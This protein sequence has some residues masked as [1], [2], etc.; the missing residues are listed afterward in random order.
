MFIILAGM[1]CVPAFFWQPGHRCRALAKSVITLPFIPLKNI[2]NIACVVGL[3]LLCTRPGLA[4]D[5]NRITGTVVN[6]TTGTTIASASIFINGTSKGTVSNSI[7]HFALTDVPSKGSYELVISSIGYTTLIFPFSADSLPIALIIQLKPK[8]TELESIVVEPWEKDGWAK[9][10]RLFTE[11]FVGTTAASRQCVI[12]NYKALRFRYSRKT[13]ILVAVA[14]EPLIIENKALGYRIQ[15]QLED[16]IYNMKERTL[17]FV[18]YTLFEDMSED[19][20]RIPRRWINNRKHAYAGSMMHF[21]RSLYTNQLAKDGFEVQR[22][23]KEPNLEKERVK[24]EYASLWRR[25]IGTGSRIVMRPGDTA[26]V[27]GDSTDYYSRILRQPDFIDMVNPRLLTAD[28]ILT[29]SDSSR[30]FHFPHYLHI[31]FK[32]GMEEEAYLQHYGEFRKP[33]YPRSDVVLLQGNPII[34]EAT[35][36]YYPPQELFSSGYWAWSEKIAHMLPVDF[37]PEKLK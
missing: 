2:I 18:G 19:R 25:N 13:N 32:K 27:V 10:G 3:L 28:S 4:Q 16:F 11:S 30:I 20:N 34:V 31:T 9:W 21:M 14:D 6:A 15:Y 23:I 35:G 33:W 1:K 22:M 12:K 8:V 36:A 5:R 7:G 29:R 17:L 24:K 37:D 26:R